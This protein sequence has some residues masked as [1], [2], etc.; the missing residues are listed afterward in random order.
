MVRGKVPQRGEL[1]GEHGCANRLGDRGDVGPRV[2][3]ADAITR[4]D[5]WVLRARDRGRGLLD[6]RRRRVHRTNLADAPVEVTLQRRQQ[7]ICRKRQEHGRDRWRQDFLERALQRRLELIRSAHVVRPL[8]E[9]TCHRGKIGREDR[10][11]YEQARIVL[12]HCHHQRHARAPRVVEIAEAVTEAGCDMQVHHPRLAGRAREAHRHSNGDVLVQSQY[13]ADAGVV[14]DPI[15][16]WQLGGAGITEEVGDSL[17]FEE[18]EE[19]LAHE[20]RTLTGH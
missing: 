18:A 2:R 10:L 14:A 13:V 17:G 11:M 9:R 3:E 8:R 19:V 20:R 4:D 12:A 15:D 7:H 1:L 5:D 16:E 6:R